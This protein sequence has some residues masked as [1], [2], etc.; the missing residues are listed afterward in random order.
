MEINAQPYIKFANKIYAMKEPFDLELEG[1]IYAVFPEED[2]IYT[3]FLEGQEYLK[4]QKDNE[5]HWI[6]IDPDTDNPVFNESE[7][8]NLLGKLILEYKEEEDEDE[9]EEA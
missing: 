8:A 4:I 7:E 5:S 9:E 1:F 6:V 3:I 2:D